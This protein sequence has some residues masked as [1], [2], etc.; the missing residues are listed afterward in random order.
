MAVNWRSAVNKYFS[1][2]LLIHLDVAPRQFLYQFNRGIRKL[3]VS[4]RL[5]VR[6][7]PDTLTET[8]FFIDL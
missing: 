1:S 7:E 6:L 4:V 3:L 5:A 8:K 2:C